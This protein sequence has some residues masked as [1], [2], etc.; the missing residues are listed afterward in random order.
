MAVSKAQQAA[1]QKYVKNNYDRF[2][3]T[4]PKGRKEAIKAAADAMGQSVNGFIVEA[5]NEKMARDGA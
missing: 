3:V 4:V 5:V 2:V 1:V